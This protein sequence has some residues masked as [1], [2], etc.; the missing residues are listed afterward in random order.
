M[1][2]KSAAN[3]TRLVDITTNTRRNIRSIQHIKESTRS[4]NFEL[5]IS[6]PV[7]KSQSLPRAAKIMIW[8][9]HAIV[10][11][12]SERKKQ[13]ILFAGCL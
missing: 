5:I 2:L 1:Q 8:V 3:L 13:L 9:D 11:E 12:A 10:L 4:F 6:A 7:N